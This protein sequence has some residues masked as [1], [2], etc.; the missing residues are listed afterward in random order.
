VEE[1]AASVAALSDG[2]VEQEREVS[3]RLECEEGRVDAA[4]SSSSPHR[5]FRLNKLVDPVKRAV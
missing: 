5:F 4:S 3:E 1:A 2:P